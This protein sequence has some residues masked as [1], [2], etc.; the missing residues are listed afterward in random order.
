MSTTWGSSFDQGSTLANRLYGLRCGSC[1]GGACSS[2]GDSYSNGRGAT[3]S[4]VASTSYRK[5]SQFT[6]EFLAR[7]DRIDT[8]GGL[9]E[10]EDR[11]GHA[12]CVNALAWS[13]SGNM[14]ATGSDDQDI[15]LWR[16]GTRHMHPSATRTR[17]VDR[18]DDRYFPELDMG[19]SDVIQTG[20]R[21][22][23]FSVK[24]APNSSDTRLLSCAG[25]STVR[26][27]DL[28]RASSSARSSSALPFEEVRTRA[29]KEYTRWPRDNGVC[30]RVLRCHKSRAKRISTENSPDVFL[31]CA[32]DGEVRQMDLRLPVSCAF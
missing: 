23:I 26:V 17:N 8:L 2:R 27:F 25:D 15:I 5:R 22:N 30:T 12:G 1:S 10:E 6:D 31:T 24:W 21:A 20:H 32:E 13:P 14:L 3:R 16:L 19:M 28:T 11:V 9:D 7:L 18:S 29:G 4:V